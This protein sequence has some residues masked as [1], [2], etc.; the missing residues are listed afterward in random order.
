MA[1][2]ANPSPITSNIFLNA[3]K[4]LTS[5][6]RK[7]K[8]AVL[9]KISSDDDREAFKRDLHTVEKGAELF[10][11]KSGKARD[12]QLLEILR[13]GDLAQEIFSGDS[14]TPFSS[15]EEAIKAWQEIFSVVDRDRGLIE[16]GEGTYLPNILIKKLQEHNHRLGENNND[17][18]F[19]DYYGA[20]FEATKDNREHNYYEGEKGSFED[21][22]LE[23]IFD[24][25]S[26]VYPDKVKLENALSEI[27]IYFS[28]YESGDDTTSYHNQ[29]LDSAVIKDEWGFRFLIC[30]LAALAEKNR[31][32]NEEMKKW[33]QC[34]NNLTLKDFLA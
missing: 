18:R 31:D 14:N 12:D 3:C 27:K 11:P 24:L 13:Q 7:I 26:R 22:S 23:K 16:P 32:S 9:E 6:L 4:N 5:T 8:S 1:S 28:L 2:I 10:T 30:S 25:L 19:N 29:N 21:Q 15:S 33:I 20:M 34:L 17:D